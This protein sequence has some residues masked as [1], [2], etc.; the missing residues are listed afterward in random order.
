MIK[1]LFSSAATCKILDAFIAGDMPDYSKV[2]ITRLANVSL[3]TAKRVWPMLL[4][5]EVIV[6][7]RQVSGVEMFRLNG[8]SPIVT[9]L[10]NLNCKLADC[11]PSVCQ[12]VVTQSQIIA[13]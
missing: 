11:S 12:A 7:T 3:Y 2:E 5:Y 9:A 6:P 1:D 10:R 13:P 8:K 4:T